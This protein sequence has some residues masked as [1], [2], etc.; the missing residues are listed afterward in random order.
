MNTA[1]SSAEA[2]AKSYADSNFLSE[3]DNRI[4]YATCDTDAATV[5]KT[6]T[7]TPTTTKFT[8]DIGQTVN[9]KFSVANSADRNNITLSVNGTTAKPIRYTAS[10]GGVAVLPGNGYLATGRTYQFVYDGT[11]WVCQMNYNTNDVD[12][13]RINNAVIVAENVTAYAICGRSGSGHKK[14]VSGLAIDLTYPI[15]YLWAG[16]ISGQSYAVASGG[17]STAF[18]TA[19]PSVS[20]RNTKAS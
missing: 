8:L 12:R 10:G 9:I 4:W 3:S 19:A 11:Y 18:Y 14:L 15:A 1:I 6:A 5:A 16:N 2:A 20:L 17:T 7:I 13:K